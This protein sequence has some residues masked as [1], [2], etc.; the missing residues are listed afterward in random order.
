MRFLK[1]II[2]LII[3][4][5]FPLKITAQ[6]ANLSAE[7]IIADIYEQLAEEAEM[8]IDF[9]SFYD[10]LM[11]L[12]ENPINL[13]NTN[14]DELD[15]LAFLSD[16]QID[17]ILHYLYRNTPVQTIYELQLI[18]GLDMTDIQ[19]IL[20]FV[21][22]G[23]AIQKKEKLDIKQIFKYGK[24]ELHFRLDRGLELR[25]GY[26][27]LPETDEKAVEANSKKYLGDPFYNHLKY[28]FRYRDKVQFGI[29]TEKDPG[30]QFWG[31]HNKGYDFYSAFFELKNV[32]RLKTLVL[33]DFRA[34]FGQGLVMRTDFSMGKSAYVM[35]VTP[36]STGLKKFSSTAEYDIFRGAGATINLG[37]LDVT[38]F[39]SRKRIDADTDTING[40]FS[41]LTQTGIHRTLKDLEKKNTVLQQVIGG[42]ATFTHQWFQVGTTAFY[43]HFDHSLQPRSANYNQFYFCG[44]EQWAASVNYRARWQKINFFGETAITDKSALATLNGMNF[45]P[46]SRVSLVALHRYFSKEYDVLF[47]RTFSESSRVNNE[48]GFYLGAEVRPIKYWKISA[49]VDSYRFPWAKF[50]ID[51]PSIGKDYLVQV[52]YFPKRNINMYWRFKLEEKARNFTDTVSTMSVVTNQTKWQARYLLNYTFGRFSFRNQLDANGFQHTPKQATYGFSALQDVAYDFKKIPL[53]LNAR[54]QIFDAQNY[55]NRIYVYERDVLYAFSVPMNYGLGSRYYLNLRYDLGESLSFWLKFAQTVYADGRTSQSSGNEEI[56]GNRKTDFRFLLRWKF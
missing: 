52:D 10:D 22:L 3:L 2:F 15:K 32:G 14:K 43:N 46:T 48:T 23:D 29:T 40:T 28:R 51:V 24:N 47:A 26:R 42:N 53:H 35:Q 6:D 44:Q 9:T 12:A 56:L 17:N 54:F 25:E 41:S 11:A 8:E 27:F 36:R 19:R 34:N 49:Y 16:V 20:H 38:A 4:I 30:E 18:D 50:G 5:L 33:G 37:K 55:N 13:N 39:Y 1:N 45:N 31:K 21:H 7:Q